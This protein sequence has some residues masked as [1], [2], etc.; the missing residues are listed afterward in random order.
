MATAQELSPAEVLAHRFRVQSLASRVEDGDELAVLDVG[1]QDT[2]PGSAALALRARLRPGAAVGAET[3]L[4][5]SIRGAP[6]VH[7]RADVA[8]LVTALRPRDGADLAARLGGQADIVPSQGA[9]GV[10]VL[11]DVAQAMRDVAGRRAIG[12]PELSTG[13]TELLGDRVTRWCER[14]GSRHVP[15]ALFRLAALPAGLVLE[16]GAAT[17]LRRQS[18]PRGRRRDGAWLARRFVEV[19]GPATRAGFAAWLGTTPAHA[20]PSWDAVAGDLTPLRAGGATLWAAGD[21]RPGDTSGV[22]RL[23]PPRD[24]FLAGCDRDL[25]VGDRRRRA[26]VWRPVGSPGV[27]V[28][29]GVVRGIWRHRGKGDVLTVTVTPFGRVTK[30]LRAALEEEATEVARSR[31]HASARLTTERGA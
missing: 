14:C 29:D 3:C 21:V 8:A 11:D 2:P 12:K 26:A 23:L 30:T 31:G 20:R 22:V 18:W 6:H 27:V 4:L 28:E 7:R 17:V 16:P 19:L 24:P 25:L 1:V 15:D 10:A 5:W 9:D 13:V